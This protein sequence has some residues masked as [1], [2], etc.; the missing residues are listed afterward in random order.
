[1]DSTQRLAD[2]D[3]DPNE[4]SGLLHVNDPAVLTHHGWDRGFWSV[5]DELE[6]P[7]CLTLLGH[8]AGQPLETGWEIQHLDARRVGYDGPANDAESLTHHGGWV[9]FFGSHHGGKD[10]PIRRRQHWIARFRE[11]DVTT[12]EP[13][14]VT[15]LHTAF[16]VH[17]L[18]NDAL[19]AGDVELLPMRPQTEAA[20]IDRTMAEEVGTA[21]H[22]Q[23]RRGDWTINVEGAAF[24][25]DGSLLLGLRFPVTADGRPLVV[26]LEGVPGMFDE[27]TPATVS[28]VWSVD[29]VGRGGDLAG[30]RDMCIVDGR[31]HLVTGDLDSAGKGSVIRR[32]YPGG[33]ETVSTHFVAELSA[34]APGGRLD[35]VAL[36]EFPD[37]PRIEGIAED[38]DGR[39]F[40]VSDE[41]ESVSLRSTPLLSQE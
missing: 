30:V 29:A 17:R 13:L 40:Y 41:D 12:P 28:A 26:Q 38:P 18:V 15:V 23:V 39:F 31:L 35:A 24:M 11:S 10:G 16:G 9:Y 36:C 5:L 2:L 32:E 34:A 1:M 33:D 25:A 27:G 14:E 22:D 8:R 4:A 37:R 6:V 19:L 20:F 7:E 21:A 3:L